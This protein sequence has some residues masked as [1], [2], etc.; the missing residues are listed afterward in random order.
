[1]GRSGKLVARVVPVAQLDPPTREAMWSLFAAHYD[2]A[3]RATF[4]RDLEDKRKVILARDGGD[5]SIQ[6]FSTLT[7]DVHRHEG[8]AF[9]AI[10]SGDTIVAPAYWGQKAL[11]NAFGRAITRVKLAHPFTPV[12]WFLVSKG[13]KTYLLLTRNFAEHW[14]RH[15]RATPPW[16]RG[17]LDALARARFG[18]A[19]DPSRGVVRAPEKDRLKPGVAPLADALLARAD[20]RFFHEANPGHADGDEL[21]CLGRV[22]FGSW[23]RYL[24]KQL[25]RGRAAE[26]TR[27]PWATS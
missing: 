12:Y 3:T 25:R 4:A 2:G 6:G 1:M 14:P 20:V 19:W 16:H 21:A 11:Q 18:A 7:W 8:R 5:G 23:A 13:Y 10:F 22:G 24:G 17:A 27:E 26:R 9:V 15:D